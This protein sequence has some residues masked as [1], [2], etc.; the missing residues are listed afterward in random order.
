MTLAEIQRDFVAWLRMGSCEAAGRFSVDAGPGLAVYQNNFR[1][2]LAMC[3]EESFER[4]RQ[5]IG[6]EAFHEAVIA[7]VARVPPSSWTLD[8]Y[9]RDFPDTLALL[10]PEDPEVMELARLELAL[11]DAFVGPD[12]LSLAAERIADVDWDRAVLVF[13]PTLDLQP[14]TTNAPAIWSALA[15]EEMPP[16]CETLPVASALMTWRHNEISRF[17]VIGAPE[18]RAIQQAR[19]GM[20]FAEL[21]EEA[22]GDL[23]ESEG[24]ALA[25]GWLGQ[26]LGDGLIVDIRARR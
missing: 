23:G 6:G 5:W 13:T 26:W 16:S 2:Q 7:H 18:R 20:T 25:G 24:I 19:I 8:A 14:V 3:L 10:Y 15:S 9:P 11:A 21:C 4:T 22:V 17:R 1:A 12:V